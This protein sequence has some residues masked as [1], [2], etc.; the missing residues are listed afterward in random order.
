[1]GGHKKKEG[2][3]LS[4]EAGPHQTPDASASI[5]EFFASRNER[6][7]RCCLSHSVHGTLLQQS[8]L[9]HPDHKGNISLSH[10]QATRKETEPS[11]SAR[12]SETS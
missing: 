4:Q 9:R 6:N 10:S 3:G 11:P 1:M 7:A 12:R 2:S 5:L 8:E